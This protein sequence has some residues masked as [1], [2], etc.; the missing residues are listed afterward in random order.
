[1]SDDAGANARILMF[2]TAALLA[3]MAAIAGVLVYIGPLIGL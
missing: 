2:K 3:G 1:M